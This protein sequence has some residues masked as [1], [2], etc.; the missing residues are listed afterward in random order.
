MQ[1]V[2]VYNVRDYLEL[3]TNWDPSKASL[4]GILQE[5][6]EKKVVG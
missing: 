3:P 6:L 1:V 5:R 2:L 4:Y